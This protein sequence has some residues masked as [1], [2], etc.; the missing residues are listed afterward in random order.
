MLASYQGHEEI[1]TETTLSCM[2]YPLKYVM[3]DKS[4]EKFF[5]QKIKISTTP[6]KSF[7][8]SEL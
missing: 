5:L 2:P 1:I 8:A 7:K 4:L 6:G 3:D